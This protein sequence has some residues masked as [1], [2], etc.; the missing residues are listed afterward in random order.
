MK[1]ATRFPVLERAFRRTVPDQDNPDRIY[2][3]VGVGVR[4]R[5]DL[6]PLTMG[7]ADGVFRPESKHSG[8]G[9]FWRS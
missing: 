1:P 9:L 7:Q 2:Q 6:L 8:Q 3:Q 4:K 5:L